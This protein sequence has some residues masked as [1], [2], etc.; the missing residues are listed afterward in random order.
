MNS[1]PNPTGPNVHPLP[2]AH[3]QDRQRRQLKAIA[4][5][6]L[7]EIRRL[8]LNFR[9]YQL[10]EL[11]LDL[12]LGWGLKQVIVPKLGIFSLLTGVATSHVTTALSNLAEMKLVEVEPTPKGPAYRVTQCPDAWRCRMRV[13][14]A[15]RREAINTIKMFNGL[16]RD[17][18]AADEHHDFFNQ[19]DAAQVFV[20]TLTETVSLT[21]YPTLPL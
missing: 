16:E 6:L 14:R 4:R 9:E 21:D 1:Q 3:E 12:S 19:P 18:H 11:I 13:S 2:D 17:D 10:A 20:A 15:N 7:T 5:Q 8:D